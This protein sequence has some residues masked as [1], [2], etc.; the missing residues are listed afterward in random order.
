ILIRLAEPLGMSVAFVQLSF[1]I[2]LIN[3]ILAFFNL[4]PIP[5]LDGHRIISVLLPIRFVE[6][7]E[8]FAQRFGIII[9]LFFV[10]F[11]WGPIFMG[12][13]SLLEILTGIQNISF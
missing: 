7:F 2:V 10:L 3:S 6:R 8:L 12:L 1:V 11:L 4:I 13:L 5:P 9:V